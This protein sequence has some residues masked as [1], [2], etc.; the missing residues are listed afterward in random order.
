MEI[1]PIR[2][3][4]LVKENLITELQRRNRRYWRLLSKRELR[5]LL[6]GPGDEIP[7]EARRSG[8]RGPFPAA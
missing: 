3:I 1:N 2:T 6:R 7:P 4:D 8:E 5:S